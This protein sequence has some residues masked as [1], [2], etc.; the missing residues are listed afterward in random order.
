MRGRYTL[1]LYLF[2]KYFLS[3]HFIICFISFLYFNMLFENNKKWIIKKIYL[4]KLLTKNKHKKIIQTFL[5]KKYTQHF[6]TRGEEGFISVL[7]DL[8]SYSG[9]F[10]GW[11]LSAFWPWL[12]SCHSLS[13]GTVNCLM[14]VFL[15]AILKQS[16]MWKYSSQGHF[17]GNLT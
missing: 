17:L 6:L 13:C 2:P 8:K 16:H 1:F 15:G 3:P 7:S 4:Y 10:P 5:W 12:Y 9:L 11:D 14:K